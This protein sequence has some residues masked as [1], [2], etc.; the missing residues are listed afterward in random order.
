MVNTTFA[1]RFRK[2]DA[3]IR[4]VLP[5]ETVQRAVFPAY[6]TFMADHG[7]ER[8][9]T[10][11][12]EALEVLTRR[13]LRLKDFHRDAV[14]NLTDAMNEDLPDQVRAEHMD[15]ALA[16]LCYGDGDTYP[17]MHHPATPILLK[18]GCR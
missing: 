2:S 4:D 3:L 8:D 5:G 16:R 6:E 11:A 10:A 13:P 1:D 7:Y 12:K 15:I 18:A 9:F 17:S 14:D